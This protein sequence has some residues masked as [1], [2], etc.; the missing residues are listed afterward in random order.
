MGKE[1]LVVIAVIALLFIISA[2]FYSYLPERV[3]SHWDSQGQVNGYM[4]RFWGA[5]LVP[6]ISLGLALLFILIPKIDPLKSN[7]EKFRNYFDWFIVIFLLFMLYVHM[8]T[9]LWNLGARFNMLQLMIPAMGLLF[10]YMGLLLQKAKRNWFIGIRT[11]WTLSSDNVWD[12]THRLGAKL[13][14]LAGIIA[15]LGVLLPKIAIWL[16]IVPVITASI[17]TIAYSYFE[18]KKEKRK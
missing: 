15:L 1:K 3:A 5:F 12:K 6:I 10:F 9:I 2:F 14:M 4:P 7:I 11:P 13:Y 17:Y 16:V 18:Y 8:L